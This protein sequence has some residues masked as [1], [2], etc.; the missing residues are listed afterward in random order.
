[1]SALQEKGG[2]LFQDLRKK[3]LNTFSGRK[4]R[5]RTIKLSNEKK[6]EKK[7]LKRKWRK[8]DN[9]KQEQKILSS[10]IATRNKN[11]KKDLNKRWA[12]QKYFNK[13]YNKDIDVILPITFYPFRRN[14]DRRNVEINQRNLEDI[15]E[16]LKTNKLKKVIV[17]IRLKKRLTRLQEIE[18]LPPEYRLETRLPEETAEIGKRRPFA[19]F[20]DRL[21]NKYRISP[22]DIDK[23][24]EEGIER[25]TEGRVNTDKEGYWDYV[26][27][28]TDDQLNEV[29]TAVRRYLHENFPQY[30]HEKK[31]YPDEIP[32]LARELFGKE[33]GQVNDDIQKAERV[34]SIVPG[35]PGAEYNL[36]IA[37]GFGGYLDRYL[38][39]IRNSSSRK[40]NWHGNADKYYSL[41]TAGISRPILKSFELPFSICL[42]ADFNHKQRAEEFPPGC[43]H[44]IVTHPKYVHI[45][46]DA[47][48]NIV[49]PI[50]IDARYFL[51]ASFIQDAFKEQ[52]I[53]TMD[54]DLFNLIVKFDRK[55]LESSKVTLGDVSYLKS[56]KYAE[57][58]TEHFMIFKEDFLPN[59]LI[60]SYRNPLLLPE[61]M[62]AMLQPRKFLL[63]DPY[64]TYC[65]KKKDPKLWSEAF[66]IQYAGGQKP[67]DLSFL[68][69]D[70]LNEIEK[71]FVDFYQFAFVLESLEVANNNSGLT[72]RKLFEASERYKEPINSTKFLSFIRENINER[73]GEVDILFKYYKEVQKKVTSYETRI[74]TT[75]DAYR[76][77]DKLRKL[78]FPIPESED[79]LSRTNANYMARYQKAMRNA[80]ER[81]AGREPEPNEEE[82]NYPPLPRSIESNNEDERR[83]ELVLRRPNNFNVEAKIREVTS[84]K[85]ELERQL[86]GL[87][88][89]E[90]RRSRNN[91]NQEYQKMI[92]ALPK[93]AWLRSRPA[94]YNLKSRRALAKQKFNTID[95]INKEIA[96]KTQELRRLG[97]DPND[98]DARRSP[99]LL[100]ASAPSSARSSLSGFSNS[101][102][103]GM[104]SARSSFSVNVPLPPGP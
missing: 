51:K 46:L 6:Q 89:N 94:L 96:S 81:Q 30:Y 18:A 91:V 44:Y 68:M 47:A 62:T 88:N 73:P 2:G 56:L 82:R 37:N 67:F 90:T 92:N 102:S 87:E 97:V 40:I 27:Y 98:A 64:T 20:Y 80:V 61:V 58:F 8:T 65:N 7:T 55:L 50:Q 19:Y 71:F 99:P 77:V 31:T 41:A 79:R 84:Q 15:Q 28:A 21:P 66:G 42:L 22:I 17:D 26:K 72:D 60:Y 35:P 14:N 85:Q 86:R 48:K 95:K 12:I 16:R 25:D 100:P 43:S 10:K 34:D 24:R 53:D 33:L 83:P 36:Y 93:P 74:L 13:Y 49:G 70:Y 69:Y 38:A 4:R 9:E 39:S 78:S 57:Y 76:F 32:R 54:E 3:L 1:M 52:A 59:E 103:S 75:A 101:G 104:S 11:Y 29:F 5:M 45:G 63:S 23:D